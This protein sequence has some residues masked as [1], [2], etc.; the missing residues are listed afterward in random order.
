[1]LEELNVTSFKALP[2]IM[3]AKSFSN[4]AMFSRKDENENC[5]LSL[6]TNYST[7]AHS[8]LNIM[9]Q[10]LL[11]EVF[12]SLNQSETGQGTKQGNI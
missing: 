5:Y 9:K 1:M 10:N 11:R 3:K 8:R 7:S 12:P 4:S 2:K 6:N